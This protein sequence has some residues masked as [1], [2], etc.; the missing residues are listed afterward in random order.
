MAIYAFD[1]TMNEDKQADDED[2]NVIKFTEAY[3]QAYKKAQ[4]RGQCFYVSGVG[5]RYS[6]FGAIAGS[7]G[8]AGG[9]ARVDEA[10]DALQENFAKG[11]EVIDIIG[12]SRGAAL[13]LEFANQINDRGVIGKASPAVRFIALWDTVASFGLPGNNI[14]LS[15]NL[16]L[17]RNVE[18]CCHALSLDERRL[19]FPLTRVDVD[20][21]S[22]DLTEYDPVCEV[23]FR[24][25]HSDVG[26]GNKNEA[27]SSIPLVWM[28]HMARKSGIDIPQEHIE[29][30]AA[31]CDAGAKCKKPGMDLIPNKKRTIYRTDLVHESVSRREKVAPFFEGNNPPKGLRVMGYSGELVEKRFQ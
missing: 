10:F 3:K 11:D 31:K 6:V 4:G 16:T 2:T 7:L 17:P 14:N 13:A 25:F 12:F 21:H 18:R 1:G 5:T 28:F 29:R 19:T 8:G 22:D 23:W 27:L 30:H 20:A 15:F 24:G 26:G 9:Q